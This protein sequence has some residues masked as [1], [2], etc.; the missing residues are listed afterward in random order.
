MWSPLQ[1]LVTLDQ[2]KA[3]LRLPILEAVSPAP[4]PTADDEDLQ[5]KLLAAHEIVF[6]YL[7]QRIS[8]SD[9]WEAVVDS[10]TAETAPRRVIA[11]ILVQFTDLYR[12]RGDD[13]EEYARGS[14][15]K[16]QEG[17]LNPAVVAL[18]Y[19]LRDPALS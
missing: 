7:T 9:S 15:Y 4:P 1:E 11:A 5:M 14:A 19:R 6:D 17:A 2:A 16:R 8:D 3:H 18:L 10:W 12:F 13:S